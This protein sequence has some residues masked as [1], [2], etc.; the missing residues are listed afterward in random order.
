MKK[1]EFPRE[2]IDLDI[3]GHVFQLAAGSAANANLADCGVRMA[4]YAETMYQG[5]DTEKTADAM[6]DAT[7]FMMDIIEDILGEGAADDIFTGREPDYMDCMAVIGFITAAVQEHNE[8]RLTSLAEPANRERR[9]R[10][11]V[12]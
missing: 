4:D 1:F 6:A 11:R 12:R 2:V 7:D 3:A 9:R 8:T 5:N 10:T